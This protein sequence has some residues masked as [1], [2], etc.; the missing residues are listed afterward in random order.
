MRS[1]NDI[2]TVCRDAKTTAVYG[3]LLCFSAGSTPIGF[4]NEPPLYPHTVTATYPDFISE[5][6]E[7]QGS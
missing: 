1:L 2:S 4:P 3:V 7:L 5:D 6:T